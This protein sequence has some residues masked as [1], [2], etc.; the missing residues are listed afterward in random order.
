MECYKPPLPA[1]PGHIHDMYMQVHYPNAFVLMEHV[2]RMGEGI[3]SHNRHLTVGRESFLA[4]AAI[5]QG[6]LHRTIVHSFLS[7]LHLCADM[8]GEEDGSIP[9]TYQVRQC[10]T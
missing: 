4:M 8:Y 9:V 6:V 7:H 10:S 5:Y 3:A 2:S 1:L